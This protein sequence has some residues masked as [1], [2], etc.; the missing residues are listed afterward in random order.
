MNELD[1]SD[2]HINETTF[3]LSDIREEKICSLQ[4][5]NN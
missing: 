2:T 5:K 4:K 1:E 3:T